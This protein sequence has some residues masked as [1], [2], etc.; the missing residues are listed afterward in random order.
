MK[1]AADTAGDTVSLFKLLGP[2]FLI[3]DRGLGTQGQRNR[4]T[5]DCFKSPATASR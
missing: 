2:S 5:H 1:R 4:R 3:D